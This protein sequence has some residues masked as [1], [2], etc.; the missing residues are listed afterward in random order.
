MRNLGESSLRRKKRSVD[1]MSAY[2][3]LPPALRRWLS[4]AALPWS[5][6]SALRIWSK[7]RAQ[8]RTMEETLTALSQAEQAT[9][10]RDR[11]SINQK[12]RLAT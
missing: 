10:A 2:D 5:P 9:L 4:Q 6:T 11:A 1:P 8:G 7:S 12:I 3:N